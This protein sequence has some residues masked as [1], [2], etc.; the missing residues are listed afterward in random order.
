[1]SITERV[2]SHFSHRGILTIWAIGVTGWFLRLWAVLGYRPTCD[3]PASD[4][5]TL[6]GDAY[7]HHH[8]AN[9]INDGQWFV[10]PLE[11]N[12]NGLVIDSAGDPPLYALYLAFWS[13]LGLDGITDHRLVSTLCGMAFVVLVGLFAR[14]LAGDLAGVIAAIIAALHPLMWVN[15]IMLLSEGLYQPLV[16]V[17]LWAAYD[18]TEHPDRRRVALLGAAIALAALT[19]AEAL[20]LFGLMV[21]PLV[22][23]GTALDR[24]EK[25]RQIAVCWTVGILVL[26]PWI[27]F[28][29]VRFEKPVTISAVSGTVLMAGSCDE[30]WSGESMGFWANCF[31]ARD[32]WDELEEELPG[33]TLTG[34]ER[35]VYD[36]SVR[37]EF[38]RSRA[39]EYTIDNWQRYPLV[40]LARIGRSLEFFRVGHTLRM[41]YLVEGRWEEPSTLG[42]GLYYALVP[43]TI[44]GALVLRRSGRR[45]TPLLAMWPVIMLASV[46]T[47]G[48][49]RYRVPIDIAM[50]VMAAVAVSWLV[51][52]LRESPERVS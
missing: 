51:D 48:L 8:Q 13:R 16:V 18:W 41:N 31:E 42:L 34:D 37:D 44:L 21:L 20:S 28:N 9:L 1:V 43:L 47:F 33:V 17:V 2:R 46:T 29:M 50:I 19:R 45:L 3:T 6:A 23:W 24:R 27:G 7:Y 30:A 22:L 5:Y 49:T 15:D 38:N 11:F 4:C 35:V 52:R 12:N 40:A 14:R 10:N 25:L 36:E 32:L 26:A 39:L